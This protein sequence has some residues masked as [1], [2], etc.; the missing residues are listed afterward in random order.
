[1]KRSER[2]LR[3]QHNVTGCRASRVE[4]DWIVDQ[5]DDAHQHRGM[6]CCCDATPHAIAA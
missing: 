1:M 2:G 6:T 3:A 5:G 4:V